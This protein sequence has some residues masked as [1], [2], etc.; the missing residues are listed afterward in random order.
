[1]KTRSRFFV[2]NIVLGIMLAVFVIVDLFIFLIFSRVMYAVDFVDEMDWNDLLDAYD[3]YDY[4]YEYVNYRYILVS[5]EDAYA[6]KLGTEY[7]GQMAESGYQFYMIHAMVHN[8]GTDYTE[9][10]YLDLDFYGEEYS[11]VIWDY[12]IGDYDDPFYYTNQEIVPSCQTAEVECLV[13]VRDGVT[14]LNV[15]LTEDYETNSKD[16]IIMTLE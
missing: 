7:D 16:M 6:E 14:E 5:L 12:M 13:Q 8:A 11:D 15:E 4:N 3:D 2:A 1:M 10:K 9:T